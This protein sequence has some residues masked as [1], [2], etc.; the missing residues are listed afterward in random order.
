MGKAQGGLGKQGLCRGRLGGPWARSAGGSRW[1]E[2]GT[3][4]WGLVGIVPA[5]R[6]VNGWVCPPPLHCFQPGTRGLGRCAVLQLC[7]R[8]GAG[9]HGHLVCRRCCKHRMDAAGEEGK[10]TGLLKMRCAC[11][12]RCPQ[13]GSWTLGPLHLHSAGGGVGGM[14]G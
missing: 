2:V 5:M 10:G 14:G 9:A 7:S 4:D 6:E 8:R 3:G 1:D 13:A 11:E 12:R